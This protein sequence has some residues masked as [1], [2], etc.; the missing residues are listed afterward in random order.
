M[1][2]LWSRLFPRLIS[3][4]SCFAFL[5]LSLSPPPPFQNR[6]ERH[7]SVFAGQHF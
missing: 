2:G 5:S 1:G 7:Y 4:L 3:F 6:Q